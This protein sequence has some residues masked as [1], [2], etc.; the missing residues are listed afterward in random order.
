MRAE[1][2]L[3]KGIFGVEKTQTISVMEGDSVT[4]HTDVTELQRY[5]V[6]LWTFGPQGTHI[7]KISSVHNETFHDDVDER[8]RDRLKLDYQTGSLTI[9]NI[10]TEHN[11]LYKVEIVNENKVSSKH[12]MVKIYAH[13]PVPM[14]TKYYP[15]NPSSSVSRCVLL[16]S[17][18]NMRHVT[19]SWYK[20]NSLLSSISV[21]DLISS[22]S[23]HLDV[24]Y[25][26]KNIY[27]CVINNP[28]SNQTRHLGISQ[29]YQ[30][31]SVASCVPQQQQDLSCEVQMVP[32]ILQ[33]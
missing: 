8:F 26:D 31:H 32:C 12:F 20:E 10:S 23:L 2:I 1:D 28:I 27:S 4:L 19:L 6:I 9:T 30:I 16:C 15:Q 13:L 7:A 3:M 14:I 33:E 17:V 5:N 29:H 24:E 18:E 11:G 25:E 22:F 21:S